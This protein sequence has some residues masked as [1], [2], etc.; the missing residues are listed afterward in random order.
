MRWLKI[1]ML[2]VA[3]AASLVVGCGRGQVPIPP[4]AQVVHVVATESA[5]RLAPATVHA[6]DIYLVLD[7]PVGGSFALAQRQRTADGSPGPFDDDDLERLATGDTEYTAIEG[8]GNGCDPEQRAQDRGQMGYC[9]NVWKVVLGEGKYAILG[10]AWTEQ[11]TEA[12]AGPD[13]RPGRFHPAPD[14]GG[15]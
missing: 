3:L 4:G 9:G 10:P 2:P 11:E 15:A 5:V 7:E 1:A 6:G 13:R 12:S 14:D 8:F